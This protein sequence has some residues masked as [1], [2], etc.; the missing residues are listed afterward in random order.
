M[1]ELAITALLA[2]SCHAVTISNVLPG[3]SRGVAFS[4]FSDTN[5]VF[6]AADLIPLVV[7]TNRTFF[8]SLAEIIN[9]ADRVVDSDG[10]SGFAGNLIEGN[11]LG[12]GTLPA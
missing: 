3:Q 11:R 4:L 2:C 10:I 5:Y 1:R 8:S 9:Q 6:V 7:P 12:H